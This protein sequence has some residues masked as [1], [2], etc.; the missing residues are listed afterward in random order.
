L[1]IVVNILYF[2]EVN[3]LTGLPFL[4]LF[5]WNIWNSFWFE[6]FFLQLLISYQIYKLFFEKNFFKMLISLLYFLILVSIYLSVMQLEMFACFLFLSEFVIIVF[7]YCLF[8]HLN[9]TNKPLIW[10]NLTNTTFLSII[11]VF[12]LAV[13]WYFNKGILLLYNLNDLYLLFVDIYDI[14]NNYYMND[15]V[16]FF[17]FFFHYNTI[18][19][20]FI[21]LFLLIMTMVLLY[22]VWLYVAL[23]LTRKA[24]LKNT[25]K[26]K[27]NKILWNNIIS[28]FI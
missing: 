20:F 21:G 4:E 25:F 26:V 14:Y 22:T 11:V 9:Y 15:L 10:N 24:A 28:F 7:F 16:F 27:I 2:I 17:H 19:F 3:C 8:L 12:V 5:L 6:F 18:L 23:Y 13:I 1:F